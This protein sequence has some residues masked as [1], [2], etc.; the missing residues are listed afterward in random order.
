MD[1][2]NAQNG[3]KSGLKDLAAISYSKGSS[4]REMKVAI[5]LESASEDAEVNDS[6]DVF[7]LQFTL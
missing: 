7:F 5:R 4:P 3:S 1:A 6:F 2:R